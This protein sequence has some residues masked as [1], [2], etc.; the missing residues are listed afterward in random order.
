M[1]VPFDCEPLEVLSCPCSS[2]AQHSYIK[3]DISTRLLFFIFGQT[4]LLTHSSIH[5]DSNAATHPSSN[6][7]WNV[8]PCECSKSRSSYFAAQSTD[9]KHASQWEPSIS[10]QASLPP[11]GTTFDQTASGDT[12][13][14]NKE[15][16]FSRARAK[17]ACDGCR[18]SRVRCDTKHSETTCGTCKKKEIG[19]TYGKVTELSPKVDGKQ[20]PAS[21]SRR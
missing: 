13:S 7:K 3:L 12:G 2:P 1:W 9:T 15:S 21:T 20:G 8:F 5:I 11:S 19:C 6:R 16:S 4:R 18:Y 17:E 10:S 14:K